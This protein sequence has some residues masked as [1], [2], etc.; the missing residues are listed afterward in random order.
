LGHLP[1]LRLPAAYTHPGD[2]AALLLPGDPGLLEVAFF[3]PAVKLLVLREAREHPWPVGTTFH[4]S[5]GAELSGVTWDEQSRTL[6]GRLMRPAGQHG[7]ITLAGALPG[8][9]AV[10]VEGHP[11]PWRRTANGGLTFDLITEGESTA[12]EVRW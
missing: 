6:S 8:D 3:G 9:P 7:A 11:V 12:W 4:Q 1:R 2:T 10:T 5:G